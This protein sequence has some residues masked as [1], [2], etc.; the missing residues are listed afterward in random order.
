MSLAAVFCLSAFLFGVEG[1]KWS[2]NVLDNT[3]PRLC[4]GYPYPV[5]NASTVLQ[6]LGPFL[7]EVSKNMSK[8]LRDTPGGSVVAVVYRDTIIWTHEFGLINMSGER[9]F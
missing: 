8:V 4:P 9:K 1:L 7:E 5:A 2:R 3:S 6:A